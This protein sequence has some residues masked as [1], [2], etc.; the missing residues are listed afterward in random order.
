[1][2]SLVVQGWRENKIS[3]QVNLSI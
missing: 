3:K 1:M 2:P